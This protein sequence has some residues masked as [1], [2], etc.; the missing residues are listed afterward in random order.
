M[1]YSWS[2]SVDAMMQ[3]PHMIFYGLT[4]Q[5]RT[6]KQGLNFL[7]YLKNKYTL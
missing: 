4:K 3:S 5:N 2:P 1:D 7:N 6:L